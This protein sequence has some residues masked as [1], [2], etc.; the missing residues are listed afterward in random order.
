MFRGPPPDKCLSSFHALFK[1][2]SDF[3]TYTTVARNTYKYHQ[4][5][6]NVKILTFYDIGIAYIINTNVI[7]N[8]SDIPCYTRISKMSY[9]YTYLLDVLK[10]IGITEL[11]FLDGP[12]CLETF[13]L[14]SKIFNNITKRNPCINTMIDVFPFD[15]ADI[16]YNINFTNINSNFVKNLMEKPFEKPFKVQGV[17]H[18][19][20]RP[21]YRVV[22]LN[23]NGK[24]ENPDIIWVDMSEEEY[25]EPF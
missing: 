9:D 21:D 1:R 24:D 18:G 22:L 15:I 6:F 2:E 10:P 19:S 23:S 12:L 5:T 25:N 8:S 17:N 11:R 7:E 4:T 3:I 13:L 16:I 14:T 20:K